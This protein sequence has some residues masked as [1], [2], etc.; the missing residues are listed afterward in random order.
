MRTRH[1]ALA[2]FTM[3]A[4]GGVRI[5]Y[6]DDFGRPEDIVERETEFRTVPILTP[7]PSVYFATFSVCTGPIRVDCVVDG[8]TF[9]FKGEKYRIADID[10][11]EISEPECPEEKQAGE[12]ARD[13]L[14][15]ELNAG[16]FSMKSGWR[17]QDRYGRKLRNVIRS[18]KSIGEMLV[19]EGLA[20]RW[21]G[22]RF[23]WCDGGGS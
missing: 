8:D 23:G 5:T 19:E 3:V 13:R 9:W 17:D 11:P 10:A 15:T 2:I 18:E 14:V 20:R 21:D 12:S 6:D 7:P 22:P 1:I 4:L 16:P